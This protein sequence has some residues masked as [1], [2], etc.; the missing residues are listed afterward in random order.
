MVETLRP[1][2]LPREISVKAD[3]PQIAYR[4]AAVHLVLLV[5]LPG[6]DSSKTLLTQPHRQRIKD[7]RD[8]PKW[9]CLRPP[10]GGVACGGTSCS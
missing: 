5:A 9:T 10:L 7:G 2:L 4:S 3:L 6:C 1:E 8:A